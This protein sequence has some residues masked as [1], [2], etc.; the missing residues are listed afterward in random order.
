LQR[1]Y[2]S[3]FSVAYYDV[4]RKVDMVDISTDVTYFMFKLFVSLRVT[5]CYSSNRRLC[6]FWYS[7]K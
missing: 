3:V 4:F 6:I 1:K 5:L 7:K 2:F